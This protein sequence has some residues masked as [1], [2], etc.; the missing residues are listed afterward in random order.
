ML[1]KTFTTIKYV[2]IN[3]LEKNM[4]KMKQLEVEGNFQKKNNILKKTKQK[5]KS[6]KIRQPIK[7]LFSNHLHI[8]SKNHST[9]KKWKVVIT[10]PGKVWQLEQ[11]LHPQ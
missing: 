4:K 11:R 6:Q 8:K 3:I 2:W 10:V 1:I 5:K 9:W 7:H